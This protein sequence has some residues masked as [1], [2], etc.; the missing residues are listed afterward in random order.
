MYVFKNFSNLLLRLH[1]EILSKLKL[2]KNKFY[3]FYMKTMF[4][5]LYIICYKW[6]EKCL[7]VHIL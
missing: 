1:K 4:S 3:F 5:S 2:V 6:R 7:Y